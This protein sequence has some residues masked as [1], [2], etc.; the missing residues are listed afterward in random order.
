MRGGPCGTQGQ[1]AARRLREFRHA[2]SA[3]RDGDVD[4]EEIRK[5]Q[6]TARSSGERK[7]WATIADNAD[8][9]Q[10]RVV[11][12]FLRNRDAGKVKALSATV[13]MLS[14]GVSIEGLRLLLNR[15]WEKWNA[16]IEECAENAAIDH[17]HAVR[18]KVKTLRYSIELNQKF[19]PDHQLENAAKFLKDI[20]DRVG[21]WHDELMLTHLVLKTF[22]ASGAPPEAEAMKFIR[23]RKEVEIGLAE[24]ARDFVLSIPKTEDYHQLRTVLSASIFAMSRPKD[25]RK[26]AYISEQLGKPTGALMRTNG[27]SHHRN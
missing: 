19:A 9:Q 14:H 25:A 2:L 7:C 6:K 26:I 27:N 18:I 4:L 20:Q 1:K 17:L 16:A 11:K 23:D 12:K 8:K 22:S 21:A 3:W 15:G 13:N 24:S 5:A 10:R